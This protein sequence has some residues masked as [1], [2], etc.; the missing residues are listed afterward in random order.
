MNM[1]QVARSLQALIMAIAVMFLCGAVISLARADEVSGPEL[2]ELGDY[3]SHA[4]RAQK[5]AKIPIPTR[6]LDPALYKRCNCRPRGLFLDDVLYIDPEVDLS[7]VIG[8]SILLH[9]LVHAVQ[10]NQR[11][12][13]NGCFEANTR[14]AEAIRIQ[15]QWLEE[16]GSAYRPLLVL[17]CLK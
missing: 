5:L 8:K 7:T 14:E 11:G 16:K 3:A 17:S 1:E 2:R 13:V 4:L 15:T 9:E 12:Y 6:S 10:F